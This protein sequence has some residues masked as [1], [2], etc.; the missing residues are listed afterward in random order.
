MALVAQVCVK[1]LLLSSHSLETLSRYI[2]T[3]VHF[4]L[5][6]HK[7]EDYGETL[8]YISLLPSLRID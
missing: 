5:F 7:E 2:P 6:H 1:P 3:G 8:Y 4:H